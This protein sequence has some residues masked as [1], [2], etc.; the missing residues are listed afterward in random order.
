MNLNPE[1]KEMRGE[2][3]GHIKMSHRLDPRNNLAC[4][5]KSNSNGLE[6]SEQGRENELKMRQACLHNL[7]GPI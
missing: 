7:Q 6:P 2:G 5:R 3:E 1:L 4:S